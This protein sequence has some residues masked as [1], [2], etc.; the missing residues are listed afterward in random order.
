MAPRAPKADATS[1]R[2][3]LLYAMKNALSVLIGG[4]VVEVV[5]VVHRVVGALLNCAKYRRLREEGLFSNIA[6]EKSSAK[7]KKIGVKLVTSH[8]LYR[9]VLPVSF[10]YQ[11]SKDEKLLSIP[12]LCLVMV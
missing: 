1:A 3:L 6:K 12:R 7:F 8:Q 11:E 10:W 9:A 4:H 5:A 2:D